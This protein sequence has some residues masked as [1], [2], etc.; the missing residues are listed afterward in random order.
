MH[1]RSYLVLLTVAA[2][3][4][5]ALAAGN[6]AGAGGA[7]HQRAVNMGLVAG[8]A[9]PPGAPNN[10]RPAPKPRNGIKGSPHSEAVRPR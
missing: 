7:G 10:P 1:A 2:S 6:G 9:G 5:P 8:E 3:T 4:V